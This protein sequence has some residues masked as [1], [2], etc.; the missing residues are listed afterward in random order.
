MEKNL[1]KNLY[2]YIYIYT[3]IYIYIHI[4]ETNYFAI[5]LKLTYHCKLNVK[6]EVLVTQLCMTLCDPVDCSPPGSMEFS[7]HE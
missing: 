6:A 4:D 3:H 2:I 5:Y 1:K 7:R